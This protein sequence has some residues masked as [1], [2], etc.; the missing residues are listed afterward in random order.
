MTGFIKASILRSVKLLGLRKLFFKTPSHFLTVKE[1]MR[2][3]GMQR[4]ATLIQLHDGI[5]IT[6]PAPVIIGHPITSRFTKHYSRFSPE[7]FV[8]SIPGGRVLGTDCNIIIAPDFRVLSDVSREFGAAGGKK[9]KDF[10]VFNSAKKMPA[11]KKMTGNIAVISTC[12]AANFHHW[13]YDILP[14]FFL[15]KEAGLL[16][17]I[18][19]FLLNYR[20]LPFQQEG[21]RKLGIDEDKIINT[22]NRKDFYIEAERL[23]VPSLIEDLGTINPWVVNFLRNNFLTEKPPLDKSFRKLYISRKTVT[24]RKIINEAEVMKEFK[25]RGYKEFIPEEFSMQE[26]ATFFS[27]ADSIASVHGSGLSNLV[28]IKE[29]TKVL[30]ILAPYHQDPYYW[31]IANC[32]HSKYVGLFAEGDHPPDDADLVKLKIDADLLVDI[33]K[34]NQALDEIE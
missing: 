25:Y 6:E 18:D 23:F 32:R 10:S 26:V 5:K 21:L 9:P 19:H 28:F 8:A 2:D 27:N 30:D 24:S 4:G 14:R 1:W 12:G 22:V 16:E 3:T 33:T 13:N 34:L 20:Q 15:L 7:L 31:M 11:L 17:S 29:G